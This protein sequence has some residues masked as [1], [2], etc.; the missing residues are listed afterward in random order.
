MKSSKEL[1]SILQ[2]NFGIAVSSNIP[3]SESAYLNELK[4]KLSARVKFF[5]RTDIDRLMQAL[6]KIDV[7]DSES[8]KA[9]DLGEI[10]RVSDQLSELIIVRQI[11]KIEYARNF[12]SSKG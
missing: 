8:S 2:R 10:N 6:Y 11:K 1:A 4:V 7:D 5:I 9:F 3:D 12:N